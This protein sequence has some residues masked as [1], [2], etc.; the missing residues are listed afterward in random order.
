MARKTWGEAI[1]SALGAR[2]HE[3]AP[4][5]ADAEAI[6]PA[7]PGPSASTSSDEDPAEL[8]R[9]L[10]A[11][12]TARQEAETRA[13]AEAT[14]RREAELK[15][16]VKEWIRTDRIEPY[17]AADTEKHLL[18]LSPEAAASF[19]AWLE[20][21]RPSS[22][23]DEVV[24]NQALPV[25]GKTQVA[26]SAPDTGV[27]SRADEEAFDRKSASYAVRNGHR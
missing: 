3:P 6:D 21:K 19:I 12:E 24:A 13:T 23:T 26:P 15:A 8:R 27:P 5:D 1:L 11:S 9:R 7:I 17:R 25:G 2:A 22:L 18:S 4:D 14:A 16:R 10:A 20:S